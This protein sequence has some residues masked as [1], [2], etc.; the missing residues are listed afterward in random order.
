[1][2]LHQSNGVMARFFCTN[3]TLLQLQGFEFDS[4]ILLMKKSMVPCSCHVD[5]CLLGSYLNLFH[6]NW[7]RF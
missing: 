1:M 6:V 4:I 5:I 7:F 3:A 2:S